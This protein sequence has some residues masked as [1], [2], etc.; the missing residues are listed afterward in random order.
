MC[1]ELRF[2]PGHLLIALMLALLSGM[3][4]HSLLATSGYCAARGLLEKWPSFGNQIAIWNM[5]GA[6]GSLPLS[7]GGL[8]TF[9]VAYARLFETMSGVGNTYNDGVF[10]SFVI[11][12][13]SLIVAGV[14][15]AFYISQRREIRHLMEE[16]AEVEEQSNAPGPSAEAVT[17]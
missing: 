14:G 7:P 15:V 1:V 13:I 6:V 8:G 9:E 11:R 4:S 12:V 17:H 2:G 10:V 16:A 5:A 3:L